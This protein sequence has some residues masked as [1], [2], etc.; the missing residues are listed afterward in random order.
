MRDLKLSAADR[1]EARIRGVE[2]SGPASESPGAAEQN[3][4]RFGS[5]PVAPWRSRTAAAHRYADRYQ[6][7]DDGP[8]HAA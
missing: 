7:E 5:A 8:P 2:P 6:P 3:A 1:M 4:A